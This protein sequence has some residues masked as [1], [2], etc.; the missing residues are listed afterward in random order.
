MM[1]QFI[2]KIGDAI[3]DIFKMAVRWVMLSSQNPTIT[4][5]TV[6][7]SLAALLTW[8]TMAAGLGHITLPIADISNLFDLIV[9]WVQ[10]A[11][12]LVS[13]SVAVFG[14]ARKVYL[15]IV[16]SNAVFVVAPVAPSQA[17]Q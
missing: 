12:M 11:L 10:T 4:S 15:T 17:V 2:V 7:A 16:G 1:A 5:L 8:L 14:A 13:V 3:A 6:K 9:Q